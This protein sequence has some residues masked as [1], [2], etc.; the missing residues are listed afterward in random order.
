VWPVSGIRHQCACLDGGNGPSSDGSCPGAQEYYDYAQALHR[1]AQEAV[2]FGST[3]EITYSISTCRPPAY[4]QYPQLSTAG[5]L[6]DEVIGAQ[7]YDGTTKLIFTVPTG[8]TP[9]SCAEVLE[10]KELFPDDPSVVREWID[11]EYMFDFFETVADV[12][13]AVTGTGTHRSQIH[14]SF[15]TDR[16][17]EWG[18]LACPL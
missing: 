11:V 1:E 16:V 12:D 14:P 6:D 4:Y 9:L 17:V 13:I 18:L 8:P 2:R 7:E 10:I 3:W 15:I 5:P